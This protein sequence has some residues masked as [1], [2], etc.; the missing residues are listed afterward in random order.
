[1]KK[2][3]TS[4]LLILTTSGCA[5]NH[6]RVYDEV[7]KTTTDLYQVVWFQKTAAKGMKVSPKTG[8]TLNSVEN[9]TQD[10]AIAKVVEAAVRGA[11]KGAVPIP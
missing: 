1:M 6:Y 4:V 7:G 8:F 11:V 10:E 5:T 9:E 3:L 2:I